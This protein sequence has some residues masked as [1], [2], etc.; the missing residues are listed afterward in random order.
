MDQVDGDLRAA[1]FAC[2]GLVAASACGGVEATRY[3]SEVRSFAP[4]MNA[5]YGQDRMP[6]IVLGAPDGRGRTA[7]STDVVSLGIGGEI[8]LGFGERAIVD[9]PGPDLVVF[10]NAFAVQGAGGGVFAEL[11]EVSVSEDG[12]SWRTFA[13]APVLDGRTAWPGC[14]GWTPSEVFDPLEIRTSSTGGDA[15]DLAALGLTR[16]MY[17]RVRDLATDGEPPT[18]GFDLDAI[19]ALH[20]EDDPP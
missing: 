3:A 11:G 5:G 13:C 2:V 1:A 15:F 8:V 12:A 6:A 4:G 10:E 16:V 18:A 20:L 9:G 14:A 17:V 7:G 19:G